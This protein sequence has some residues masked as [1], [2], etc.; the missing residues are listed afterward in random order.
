MIIG[1]RG[2]HRLL[3]ARDLLCLGQCQPQILMLPSW[4]GRLISITST[5]R[6]RLSVPVSTNCKTHLTHDPPAG[7]GPTGHIASVPIPPMFGHSPPEDDVPLKMA[8]LK[9]IT[10]GSPPSEARQ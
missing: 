7:N 10:V 5:L 2:H 8:A 1:L 9:S 3:D 4:L 6:A